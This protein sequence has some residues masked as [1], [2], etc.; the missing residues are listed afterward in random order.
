MYQVILE[1]SHS[2]LVRGVRE[3]CLKILSR[4]YCELMFTR[5]NIGLVRTENPMSPGTR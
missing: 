3:S 5:A 1:M 4:L 2:V